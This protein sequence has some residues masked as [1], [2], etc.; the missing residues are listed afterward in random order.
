MIGWTPWLFIRVHEKSTVFDLFKKRENVKKCMYGGNRW[1]KK[2]RCLRQRENR[3]EK[4]RS[5]CG[6]VSFWSVTIILTYT[7]GL[8]HSPWIR[9]PV[10]IDL[11]LYSEP[12][13]L[14]ACIMVSRP[15]YPCDPSS[16]G[17]GWVKLLTPLIPLTWTNALCGLCR[18]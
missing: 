13:P 14:F 15:L 5:M 7:Y 6:L 4:I 2:E 18:H 16:D 12:I 1:E 3:R 10:S 8:T 11:G 17:W 9:W